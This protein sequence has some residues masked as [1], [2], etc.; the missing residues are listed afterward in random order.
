MSQ[1]IGALHA[2]LSAGHAQ[3]SADMG[4]ARK[5]V[6]SNASGMQKA[7]NTVKN[8]FNETA[9]ALNKYTKYAVAAAAAATVAFVKKQIDVADKMGKLA[10]QTGTTSEFLSGMAL[11]ASQ[12]GTSLESI[13]KGTQRLAMNMNDMR[14]GVGEAKESFE[15]LNL[16]VTKGDG[17]LKNAETMLK[18]VAE[19][20]SKMEDGADKTA[21]AM[22]LFGKSGAELIPMLNMGAAGIEK[23]QQKAKEMG[24]VISTETARQAAYLNDQLDILKNQ[25]V[26]VGR[27]IAL[28]LIPWLNETVSV[29]KFAKEESGTLM[30]AW[31]G[32]GAVGDAL[33][34][35]TTAQ[36]IKQ[37][38][39]QLE[40][41]K[42]EGISGLGDLGGIASKEKLEKELASLEAQLAAE[43]QAEQDRMK[44]S[45]ERYRKESEARRK[46]TEDIIAQAAAK[47]AEAEADIEAEKIHKLQVETYLRDEAAKWEELE[48]YEKEYADKQAEFREAHMRATRSAEEYELAKLKEQYDAY[49]S[50][51]DDKLALDEWYS[52]EIER[53]KGK[54]KTV[55]EEINEFQLQ[56]MRNMQDVMADFFFDPW[57]EGLDGMLDKFIDV[58]RRMAA[59]W[60]ATQA[61]MGAKALGTSLLA[62]I[63][64]YFG[65]GG[66]AAAV[67]T[68][69]AMHS[70]G[71]IGLDNIPRYH[72]GLLPDEMPAILQKGE[73]VFTKGQMEALGS[74]T[75]TTNNYFVI[76]SPDA[77]GFER[78]CQR[79]AVSI[80]RASVTALEKNVGRKEMRGLLNG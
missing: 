70:G 76:S 19:K 4:K 25:A 30:A 52:A 40:S 10:Q 11:V 2:A 55:T 77:E 35:S 59:E 48:A 8:K 50:Y 12:A 43:K 44:A 78:L 21:I 31:V 80:I 28:G 38:K 72:S 26:G 22:R 69:I 57:D 29:M 32:L 71:V 6:Q 37:T 39:K 27:E 75:Q 3:F 79:N 68:P 49:S 62:G 53:I 63:G 34:G 64:G 15:M 33:F 56:A 16:E 61:M 73:G 47:K 1:P 5:A 74:K 51:I 23:M 13:A 7:M 42:T 45:L 9:T 65:G 14:R 20:L 17:T 60:L 54:E 58:M 67:I 66:T 41:L 24:L 18:E 46:V 36:K